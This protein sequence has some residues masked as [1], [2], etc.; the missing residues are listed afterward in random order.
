M[1]IDFLK[2]VFHE[3]AS[4]DAL[5]YR[6]QGYR[7]SWLLD[8]IASHH[9]RLEKVG[10]GAGSVVV[11]HAD[12]SPRSVAAMLCLIERS[13]IIVPVAPSS[14]QNAAS[15]G[16]IAQA[17]FD[18]HLAE[19]Q[20]IE[21]AAREGAPDHP[22]LLQ[23]CEARHPGLILF[24]SGT[25]GQPKGVVHDLTRLLQKYQVRRH[26]YRTLA[27]L[28]FDHIGGVDTALYSL[29]NGSCLVLCDDRT[30]EGVCAAIE[31]HDVNVLPVAPSFLNLLS[32]NG[33]YQRHD[34]SSLKI[35]TYGAEMMPQSTLDRCQ[36]MFPGVTIMQ[37]YGTSEVG[38]LRSKS[39]SSTSL[40]VKLGGEGFGTRVVDGQLQ[41]R[42]VSSMLGYLNAKSPF[43]D[44]GWFKTGDQV[45]VDGEYL[46]FLG[47]ESDVINV[48]GQKVH[49]AEVEGVIGALENIDEVA[50]YSE[51]NAL[52]G[53]I[54]CARVRT[55]EEED[56]KLLSRRI[57]KSCRAELESYKVPVK[58]ER[59]LEPLAT[60]RF[61]LRREPRI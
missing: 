54:V 35:V 57:R 37:K 23:L 15:F 45:E 11:L 50:V 9:R 42:A 59:S 7:Y 38:T 19:G 27:F 31:S 43:T 5:V 60:S 36:E 44:D 22:L 10:I 26:C 24:S 16:Q 8:E 4:D 51:E 1:P 55:R 34:L 33:A 18:L 61:K 39:R 32:I 14:E 3:H 30:P 49:P 29:S 56:G 12:F 47:R 46:R 48:G 53:Q 25:T 41:V 2:Q 20:G 6:G 40:W 52:M 17:Q 21:V 58:I 28:L 13:A